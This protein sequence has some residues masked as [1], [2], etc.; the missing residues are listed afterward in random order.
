[1]KSFFS[2]L[3]C[4]FL[5][6]RLSPLFYMLLL[7]G[8]ALQ[9]CTSP[10]VGHWKEAEKEAFSEEL[11][12]VSSHPLAVEAGLEI[13][14][15]GGNVFDAAVAVQFALAVVYPRAGNLG[16]GGFAIIRTEAGEI[17]AQDHREVAPGAAFRE[18]YLDSLGQ[19][20]EGLSLRGHLASGV[21]GTVAGLIDI[22]EKFGQLQPFSIL[23]EPAIQYASEGF[24]I[25]ATEA[26]RLN[27]FLDQFIDANTRGNAFT[28]KT[29]WEE[30]DLLLQ[31]ELA[32]TLEA[33]ATYGA[34]G[35]YSG[36]VA[37]SL[38]AEMER[39][40]GIINYD[41]LKNYQPEW[42]KPISFQFNKFELH[43]MPPPSS[44][45]VLLNQLFHLVEKE[46]ICCEETWDTRSAHHLLEASRLGFALRADHLGDPESMMLSTGQLTSAIRLDSLWQLFDPHSAGDG[47]RYVEK[48]FTLPEAYETT[49]TSIADSR[50]NAISLTTTLNSN[51]GSKVVVGGAGFFMNNE[52]DDFSILPGLPNQFGLLG[53]EVNSVKPGRRML[54][55]MTPTIVEK[56]GDFYMAIG[57]PGGPTIISAVFQVLL[58]DF[59]FDLDLNDNISRPRFHQQAFPK[60]TRIENEVFSEAVKEEL[61]SRGHKMEVVDRMAVVKVVKKSAGGKLQGAGDKRNPDDHAAGIDLRK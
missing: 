37:D 31:P 33:I 2:L 36:W 61:K 20:I 55:S 34:D 17:F 47:L 58:R 13:Y 14:E 10:E 39:G 59:L 12:I 18:M 15:R 41:D 29:I 35:F 22:H 60:A 40:N 23:L 50:G 38:K 6:C 5:I 7:T 42:R 9:Q 3:S 44:G 46:E 1:M 57:S 52:M 8:F 21:P 26:E 30:G 54:S 32:K 56:E 4:D 19:P 11:M 28:A 43:S 53:S 27:R 16:G 48:D 24:R 25:S 51:F 49:H 45:G